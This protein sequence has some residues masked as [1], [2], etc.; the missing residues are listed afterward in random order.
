MAALAKLTLVQLKEQLA[1]R[2]NAS[3]LDVWLQ[4]NMFEQYKVPLTSE[5]VDS[6]LVLCDIEP[7]DVDKLAET[8]GMPKL[9][10]KSFRKNCDELQME[11]QSLKRRI[12]ILRLGAG[13][14]IVCFKILPAAETADTLEEQQLVS[15]QAPVARIV[16]CLQQIVQDS[17]TYGSQPAP[18]TAGAI[19]S[20]AELKGL[21]VAESGLTVTFDLSEPQL[22]PQPALER[23]S[24]PE[25]EPEP[26]PELEQ[27]DRPD[28]PTGPTKV[29][30]RSDYTGGRTHQLEEAEGCGG[31]LRWKPLVLGEAPLDEES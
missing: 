21:I 27:A 22:E 1:A 17:G 9:K 19:T 20:P 2:T 12:V 13:S 8:V 26:E 5:G 23:A 15:A 7:E 18:V 25:P 31:R 28:I 4:E 14:V 3:A 29:M 6:L 30:L 24:K 11:V 16:E 10:A